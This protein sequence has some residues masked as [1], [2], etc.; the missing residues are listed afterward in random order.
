MT[1]RHSGVL[2]RFRAPRRSQSVLR[3]TGPRS[4]LFIVTADR[5]NRQRGGIR[6]YPRLP[7]EVGRVPRPRRNRAAVASAHAG[8]VQRHVRAAVSKAVNL[9]ATATVDDTSAPSMWPPG[10]QGQEHHGVSLRQPG[11]LGTS[12]PRRTAWRRLTRSS[13]GGCAR[14]LLRAAAP[15]ARADAESQNQRF[16]RFCDACSHESHESPGRL[17]V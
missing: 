6:I 14:A 3:P 2:V 5:Q 4:G 9:P 15:M 12:T 8:A 7:A 10:R 17:A 11:R 13:S 1:T 16:L